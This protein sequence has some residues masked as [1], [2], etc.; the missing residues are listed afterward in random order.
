MRDSYVR[1][2]AVLVG[3]A[4]A[5]QS[6]ESF[7]TSMDGVT[8]HDEKNDLNF[9]IAIFS[10]NKE[11]EPPKWADFLTNYTAQNVALNNR[12]S[13]AIFC[14]R[15]AGNVV[16]FIFGYGR[17]MLDE[18]FLVPDF[19]IKTALN[20]L[21]GDSLYSIDTFSISEQPMQVR[22]QSVKKSNM[23]DFGI[24]V[25]KDI[26]KS[27]TGMPSIGVPY[28]NISGGGN[29]YAFSVKK[30]ALNIPS[31]VASLIGFYGMVTYKANYPWVD[32]VR[33]L[34]DSSTKSSLDG[35]LLAEIKLNNSLRVMLNVPEVQ[36]W[37]EIVGFSFTRAK[38][39]IKPMLMFGDYFSTIL[40]VNTLTIDSVKNDTV[41]V[42]K[43]C[44]GDDLSFSVYKTIY[45]EADFGGKKY[46][47]FSGSWYEVNA[48]FLAG[49]DLEVNSVDVANIGL[50][51]LIYN[52]AGGVETEGDY[53]IRACAALAG[54]E[55]LDKKL[56]KTPQMAS[57]IEVCDILLPNQ[58]LH[59]KHKKGGSS[60]LSHLFAQGCV[61]AELMLS[62]KEARKKARSKLSDKTLI[63]ETNYLSNNYT[64]VYVLLGATING[65][66]SNSL[67][68]F[69]KVNLVTALKKLRNM[70]YKIAIQFVP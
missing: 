11:Q 69:S 28:A 29:L 31:V 4:Y 20:T 66:L 16:I 63:P 24:D 44:G 43:I 18:K 38:S 46:I 62:Y 39:I 34:K 47:L 2:N 41:F 52:A 57:Q 70:N 30:T 13:S 23:S 33:S 14:V 35:L 60:S 22:A 8:R 53:N 56:I 26:L 7:L 42:A 1:L 21:K 65:T 37:D 68:F 17:F 40:N 5:N 9:E 58:Y 45:F 12:S 50:P 27:V 61:S 67:P 36:S 49:V 19:G 55:L 10:K 25:S 32:N 54:S 48:N 51:A 3:S 15:H 59:V 6:F 64:V